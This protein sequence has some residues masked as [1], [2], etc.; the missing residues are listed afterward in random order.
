MAYYGYPSPGTIQR[1]FSHMTAL[2]LLDGNQAGC[3]VRAGE[4]RRGLTGGLPSAS[5]SSVGI[6]T[7][8]KGLPNVD[9]EGPRQRDT[10]PTHSNRQRESSTL[11]DNS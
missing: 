8:R 10:V 4:D 6:N 7:I 2:A 3:A 9:M 11:Q 1:K 5:L